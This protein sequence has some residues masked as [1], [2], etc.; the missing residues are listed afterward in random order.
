MAGACLRSPSQRRTNSRRR[1]QNGDAAKVRVSGGTRRATDRQGWRSGFLV[2][3]IHE[4]LVNRARALGPA[5][6]YG[7]AGS[8]GAFANNL[9]VHFRPSEILAAF[10]ADPHLLAFRH[11]KLPPVW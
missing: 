11:Q 8:V 3:D 1:S 2:D 10:L 9:P 6:S 4:A 7:P 5:E